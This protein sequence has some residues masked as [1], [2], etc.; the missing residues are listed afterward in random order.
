MTEANVILLD[1]ELRGLVQRNESSDGEDSYMLTQKGQN[2]A[3]RILSSLPVEQFAIIGML[4]GNLI[5]E[6]NL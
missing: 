6:T 3:S 4:L 1:L 2:E 5:V